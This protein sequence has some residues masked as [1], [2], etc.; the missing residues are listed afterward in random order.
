MR[1]TSSG[2]VNTSH[3][4]AAQCT[5]VHLSDLRHCTP[6]GQLVASCWPPAGVMMAR[7]ADDEG[8]YTTQLAI[9]A[10]VVV[11]S[12]GDAHAQ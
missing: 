6:Y 10:N 9:A 5:A 2:V 1:Y 7:A 11:Q 8:L 12:M 4:K 3:C